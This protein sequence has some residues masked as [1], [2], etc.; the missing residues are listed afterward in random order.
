[1]EE[2]M[3]L[4]FGVLSLIIFAFCALGSLALFSTGTVDGGVFFLV[5][6]L[7]FLFLGIYL[8]R[9]YKNKTPKLN[10]QKDEASP[11]KTLD[12]I[13]IVNKN[14]ENTS[15]KTLKQPSESINT[16]KPNIPKNAQEALAQLQSKPIKKPILPGPIETSS[17]KILIFDTETTGIKSDDEILQ[18]SI[19]N[20]NEDVIIDELFRPE[21][22][23]RWTEASN[24]HG[25]YP[26]HVKDKPTFVSK[27][28]EIRELLR[29]ADVLIGY[30]I[31]FDLDMLRNNG[32]W[33]NPEG[34]NIKVIDVMSIATEVYG[35]YNAY[36]GD[37]KWVKLTTAISRSK[38]AIPEAGSAHNS[39]YDSIC[40]LRLYKKLYEKNYVPEN[41]QIKIK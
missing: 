28:G 21:S 6:T 4:V 20:W 40:T 7:I 27:S 18:L 10:D 26:R 37:K 39:L 8:I 25:I 16:V 22:K 35:R 15:S 19:I 11:P 30:N 17:E 33:V 36:F 23:K 41:L 3:K 31:N 32:T 14:S 34:H 13:N 12:S 5:F 38:T 29:S 9:S 2:K 24:I 1:M